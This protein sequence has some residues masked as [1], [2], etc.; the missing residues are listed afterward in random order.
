MRP[1][2][3]TRASE[4]APNLPKVAFS[5]SLVMSHLTYS[6]FLSSWSATTET[7]CSWTT[8]SRT[9]EQW[10]EVRRGAAETDGRPFPGQGEARPNDAT[11]EETR[12]LRR[13]KGGIHRRALARVACHTES[14]GQTRTISR[15][16]RP[17]V[18]GAISCRAA[19]TAGVAC[20]VCAH[21][22]HGGTGACC[23]LRVSTCVG[24]Q[25]CVR[26]RRAS[27]EQRVVSPVGWT[28]LEDKR[29]TRVRR[30]DKRGRVNGHA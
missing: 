8:Q 18:S 21:L 28:E 5:W 3:T 16:F 30:E 23:V 19:A 29:A 10:V 13:G 20:R 25:R 17:P 14:S 15:I 1:V 27:C 9:D 22:S 7:F 24:V 12:F 11:N 4:T 26:L 6:F 2:G